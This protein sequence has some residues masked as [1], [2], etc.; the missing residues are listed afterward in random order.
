MIGTKE[1]LAII[2]LPYTKASLFQLRK[3]VANNTVFAVKAKNGCW[4]YSRT[5]LL[6][7]RAQLQ[8]IPSDYYTS[9][10][11]AEKLGLP[12]LHTVER[13]VQRG[14]LKAWRVPGSPR[15]KW[16]FPKDQLVFKQ[17]L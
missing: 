11:V 13:M 15:G 3:W 17:S 16:R 8:P 7:V 9:R 2:G 4:N 6:K 1:A 14:E 12:G 10:E 5:D